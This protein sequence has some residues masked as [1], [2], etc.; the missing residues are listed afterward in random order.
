MLLGWTRAEEAD[1]SVGRFTELNVSTPSVILREYLGIFPYSPPYLAKEMESLHGA[2]FG[3]VELSQTL[4]NIGGGENV[5]LKDLARGLDPECS[6]QLRIHKHHSLRLLS[7]R[8][9]LHGP[10]SVSGDM[11]LQIDGGSGR[12]ALSVADYVAKINLEAPGLVVSP[13]DEVNMEN[14]GKN[15]SGR[16]LERTDQLFDEFHDLMQQ[17][18]QKENGDVFLFKTVV[19]STKPGALEAQLQSG[20]DSDKGKYHGVAAGCTNLGESDEAFQNHIG[21]IRAMLPRKPLLVQ[22]CNSLSRV[23]QALEKGADLVSTDLPSLL[24]KKGHA[25]ALNW[26]ALERQADP[27]A[28]DNGEH[29]AKRQKI[30]SS[31][32]QTMAGEERGAQGRLPAVMDLWEE[33][34]MRD[35][36]PLLEGCECHACAHHTRAYIHHLLKSKELLADVLLHAH[37]QHQVLILFRR[38][39]ACLDRSEAKSGLHGTHDHSEAFHKWIETIKATYIID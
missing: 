35:R 37:N 9:L 24:T 31:K 2:V 17:K 33:G 21:S 26:A 38:A 30:A 23:L 16:A 22:A 32:S 19:A 20:D 18:A 28:S 10:A 13:A 36:T 27:H 39:R 14:T 4:D 3:H 12:R 25:I 6:K 15:R 7:P 8:S 29:S 34:Y 5:P 1:C 11:K